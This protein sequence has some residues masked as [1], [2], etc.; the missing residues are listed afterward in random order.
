LYCFLSVILEPPSLRGGEGSLGKSGRKER[1][2]RPQNPRAAFKDD[3]K[4]ED[5]GRVARGR[6]TIFA[7]SSALNPARRSKPDG[8]DERD[9]SAEDGF[10][11]TGLRYGQK[12]AHCP[13]L[14]RSRCADRAALPE[15]V[16]AF[17]F[18]SFFRRSPDSIPANFH[19]VNPAVINKHDP[20]AIRA[21]RRCACRNHR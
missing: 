15:F 16:S 4:E 11:M 14:A 7:N 12:R 13:P 9:S 2:F 6:I 10:R 17:Q 19:F 3:R 8:V 18:F 20:F 5:S 1:S 21:D